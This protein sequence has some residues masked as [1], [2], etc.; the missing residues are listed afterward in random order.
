[1]ARCYSRNGKL[2]K[3]GI[4]EHN[5]YLREGIRQFRMTIDNLH[6]CEMKENDRS[7][8]IEVLEGYISSRESELI[9][10]KGSRNEKN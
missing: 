2:T 6:K 4:K 5:E 8:I 1:M 9:D 7:P 10:M 3:L